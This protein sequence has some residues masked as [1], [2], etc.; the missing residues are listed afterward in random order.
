[1]KSSPH[2]LLFG[3][4]LPA[5]VIVLVFIVSIVI[6]TSSR[7]LFEGRVFFYPA[8][9]GLKTGAEKRGIPA[10]QEFSDQ[11][12]VF[13][14]ELFLGPVKLELSRIVPLGTKLRHTVPRGR[15]VYID[16]SNAMLETDKSLT[17]SFDTSLSIIK[18]NLKYNFPRLKKIIFTI[19]GREVGSR[20]DYFENSEKNDKNL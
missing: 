2:K 17:V 4:L 12:E 16:L 14:Q 3:P 18:K 11:I 19:E 15:D 10:R 13:L 8:N 5:A 1:M 7:P 6:Y 9:S 20:T